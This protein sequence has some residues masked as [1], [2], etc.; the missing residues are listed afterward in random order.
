MKTRTKDSRSPF[1]T[2][3]ALFLAYL[4]ASCT[5]D[6]SGCS[7][8]LPELPAPIIDMHMHAVPADYQGPPPVAMC[9]PIDPMPTWDQTTPYGLFFLNF[10]KN[11]ACDDPIWSPMTDEELKERNM[12]VMERHNIYGVLSGIPALVDHWI[13][14]APGRFYPGRLFG[15]EEDGKTFKPKDMRDLVESGQLDLFGEI[16]NQYS[17]ILP[18]DNGMEPYWEMAEE[19]DIPVHIHVGPG[20]P[21]AIYLG[22]DRY[23]ARLHSPLVLEKM[24]TRHPGLRVVIGHAGY[25][26]LDD[27]LAVLYAHP[28]VYAEV[29]VIVFTQ[30]R[31]AFYRF[32]QGIMDAGFGKRVMFGSDQMVWPE[33][34]ER[35]ITVIEEATFLSEDQKRD[36][37]YN[38]AARFLRLSEEEIG[39]HHGVIP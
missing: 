13:T 23:E 1:P 7:D 4:L 19:L 37:F 5:Q 17:G 27:L 18:E 20:P 31:P 35:A 36:I 33:A 24:L 6:Y 22:F 25:P 28:Q 12:A 15:L 9:T 11:P 38:N 2:F 8:C 39:R 29:G 26:M 3:L 10:L 16:T 30:P 21:G 34:I 32:L 14:E